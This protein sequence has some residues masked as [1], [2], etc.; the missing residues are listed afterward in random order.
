VIAVPGSSRAD[1]SGSDEDSEGRRTPPAD[2]IG[3]HRTSQTQCRVGEG[4]SC[5]VRWTIG[6]WVPVGP[7][8]NR[9]DVFQDGFGRAEQFPNVPVAQGGERAGPPAEYVQT[10]GHKLGALGSRRSGRNADEGQRAGVQAGPSL[11]APGW[12]DPAG[13]RR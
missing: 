2:V 5:A 3:R 1:A 11:G 4:G 13:V 6:C 7:P 10:F 12:P 9:S 8:G